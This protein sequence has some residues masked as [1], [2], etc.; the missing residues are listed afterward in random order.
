M[1]TNVRFFAFGVVG[2][3]LVVS[4]IGT[5]SIKRT[6]ASIRSAYHTA[7]HDF[8]STSTS[9]DSRHF[10]IYLDVKACLSCI[11]DMSAWK[12]LEEKLP[13]CG[14]TFSLWAP[15]ADSQDVAVAMAL[16]GLSTPVRVLD[17]DA[18]GSLSWTNIKTPAKVL[19][20]DD[21]HLVEFIRWFPNPD[22]ARKRMEQLL[23]RVCRERTES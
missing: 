8:L 23:E 12:K 19:L 7:F 15:R 3:L 6:N 9:P 21:G 4:V 18:L 16:E 20:D 14:C 2:F 22:E 13:E 10:V 11:E 17:S 1:K 5:V